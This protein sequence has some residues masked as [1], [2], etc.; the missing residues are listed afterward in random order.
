MTALRNIG[1]FVAVVVVVFVIA[2]RF[3][4]SGWGNPRGPWK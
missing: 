1:I 2:S 4:G 3:K